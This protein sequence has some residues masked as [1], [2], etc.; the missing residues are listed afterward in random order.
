MRGSGLKWEG[1]VAAG[2]AGKVTQVYIQVT[3]QGGENATVI[4][5]LSTKQHQRIYSIKH[6]P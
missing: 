3:A 1:E 2:S 6:I 4:I 5:A